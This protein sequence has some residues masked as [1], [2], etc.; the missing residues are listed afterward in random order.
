MSTTICQAIARQEGFYVPGSRS[1]RNNN[2]GDIEYGDFAHKHGAVRVEDAPP[3][4]PARFAY[5]PDADAGFRAMKELLA[6]HY[7]GMTVRQ[8][9]NKYAPGV[10][11]NV[12]AYEHNVCLWTGLSPDTVIDAYL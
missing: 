2:P 5:F 11:N 10:E 3:H 12:S 9:L 8:M 7:K 6:L 4:K 1:N